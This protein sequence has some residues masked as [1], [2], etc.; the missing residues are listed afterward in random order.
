VKTKI[1]RHNQAYM[2]TC[3]PSNIIQLKC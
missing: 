1:T 2:M 3:P